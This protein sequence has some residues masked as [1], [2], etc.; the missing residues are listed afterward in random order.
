MERMKLIVWPLQ[1]DAERV[2]A[3]L[4]GGRE[5]EKEGC[6]KMA[7]RGVGVSHRRRLQR[8][9][10]NMINGLFNARI[11]CFKTRQDIEGLGRKSQY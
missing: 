6:L 9:P 7:K 1:G 11:H 2:A 10:E 8:L 3:A 4:E 5:G